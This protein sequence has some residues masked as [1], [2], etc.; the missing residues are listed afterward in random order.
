[1]KTLLFVVLLSSTA[2]PD[3]YWDF[4]GTF[5]VTRYCA[6]GKCCG[7]YA[8]GRTFLGTPARYGVVAVDPKI[9]RLRSKLKVEGFPTVFSAEDVGGGIKGKHIDIF[10]YSHS[11][12]LK[13]GK[14]KRKVWVRKKS[15]VVSFVIYGAF[16]LIHF[17]I[18]TIL[19]CSANEKA[20]VHKEN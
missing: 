16:D 12:C 17:P 20:S 15:N 6:C 4:Q 8:D 13:W 9:I 1:M 14:Q 11:R 3:G 5:R 2:K 7:R 10:H 19:E 18:D